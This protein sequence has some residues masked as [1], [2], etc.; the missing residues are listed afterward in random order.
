MLP[1]SSPERAVAAAGVPADACPAHVPLPQAA[2]VQAGAS[3]VVLALAA[4]VPA[5]DDAMTWALLQGIVA[6]RLGRGLGMQAWW[7]PIHA[8][9]APGL[10]WT[11]G[12]GLPPAYALPAFCLLGSLSWG[13]SRTRV[14]LFLSGRATV[15]AVADL[16][17]REGSFTFVDLG[18]GLGGVLGYLARA[19]PAGRYHGIESAP[20]PFLLSRLRAAFALQ[21]WRI[22]WGDFRD[23]D[24]GRYDVVY[25]YLSPAAMA[26]LWEKAR[27]EM[28][29]GSLLISNSFAV[30]GVPPGLTLAT[31]ARGNSRLL[32]WRM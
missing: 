8:L 32:L 25:A 26:G 29:S 14:P 11:L 15:Q 7:F 20:V 13:V 23:L 22:S 30:P 31:G 5:T 17:P 27:R 24:L 28:R 12:W 10:V 3:L 4:L 1:L 6:A 18:C 9:F 16:L 2:A 21:S 19:R